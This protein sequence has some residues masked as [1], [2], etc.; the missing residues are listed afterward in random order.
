MN[1]KFAKEFNQIEKELERAKK[2]LL[3]AH[4]RPDGDT[5]GSVF[6]LKEYL[7][8]SLEK[9]ADVVCL[10]PFPEYLKDVF[11]GENFADLEKIGIGDYDLLIGC[12]AVGRS[13]EKIVKKRDKDQRVIIFDHHPMIELKEIKPDISVADENYSSVCEII[14]DFLFS[15]TGD[16]QKNSILFADRYIKRYGCIPKFKYLCESYGNIG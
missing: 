14:Y 11:E 9:K 6:V 8:K 2:V 10:D 15:Q 5:I 12:D 4:S 16:K 1:Y 13:F 7:E 3:V